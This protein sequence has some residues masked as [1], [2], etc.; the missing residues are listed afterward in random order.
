[1]VIGLVSKPL[2][3]REAEKKNLLP[4]LVKSMLK[5]T[6]YHKNNMILN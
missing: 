4:F 6:R 3:E 5:N 2:S 1:M